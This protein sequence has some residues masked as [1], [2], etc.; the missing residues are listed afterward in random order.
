MHI[1]YYFDANKDYLHKGH[2]YTV[3]ANS[4]KKQHSAS[5]SSTNNLLKNHYVLHYD[6]AKII[7]IYH[8]NLEVCFDIG[9]PKRKNGKPVFEALIDVEPGGSEV[10][11]WTWS[12]QNF[13]SIRSNNGTSLTVWVLQNIL[14]YISLINMNIMN[15]FLNLYYILV[16]CRNFWL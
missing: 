2:M 10:H 7:L 14:R 5:T 15:Y 8:L 4:R 12:R 13:C 16:E 6:I 9:F 1:M 11:L 3:A